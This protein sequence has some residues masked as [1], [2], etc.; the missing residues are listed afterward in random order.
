MALVYEFL[1]SGNLD[2]WLHQHTMEEDGEHKSLELMA[3]LHNSID[4][5]ASLDYLHQHKPTPIVHS[6][7]KPSNVL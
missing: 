2:Q 1:P 6:D 4:V 7:L 3:R 5:A